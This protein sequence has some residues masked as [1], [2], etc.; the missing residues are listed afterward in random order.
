MWAERDRE[1]DKHKMLRG[2]VVLLYAAFGVGRLT[3]HMWIER[4]TPKRQ[5]KATLGLV[6]RHD[7]ASELGQTHHLRRETETKNRD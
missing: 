6:S 3:H 4:F 7:I 5:R 1:T 2:A